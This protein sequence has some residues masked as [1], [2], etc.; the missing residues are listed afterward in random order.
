MEHSNELKERYLTPGDIE[1][2]ARR[3]IPEAAE[4]GPAFDISRAA[5]LIL[6]MQA[7][8]LDKESHAVV[9]DAT[10][11]VPALCDLARRFREAGRP[12]LMTRHSNSD[13]DAGMIRTWWK[14]ILEPG[15]SAAALE[16]T[17]E[18]LSAVVVDKA[19]Y[20]AFHETALEE[21]LRDSG[22]EQV[23][24][25]GVMTHLCV[26]TTARSAFVRGFAVFV[27]ADGT[28]T[29]NRKFHAASMLNLSHGVASVVTCSG[30][31]ATMETK[32]I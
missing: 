32:R 12:V 24:V 22:T 18:E 4:R 30:L 15:S 8:F 29:Y 25:T 10:A 28:A 16:P 19:Q 27:P 26:E 17:L 23:V 31:I 7:F 5:L 14:D 1:E 2:N 20:D 9:P 21:I 3:L 6:D 11:I 13:D